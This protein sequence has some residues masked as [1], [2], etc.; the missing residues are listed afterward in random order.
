MYAVEE[1]KLN[2]YCGTLLKSLFSLYEKLCF[3]DRFLSLLKR[4]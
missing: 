4:K 2:S 3:I 1:L